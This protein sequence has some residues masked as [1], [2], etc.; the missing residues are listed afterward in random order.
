MN[1]AL[2][3]ETRQVPL[4]VM[5]GFQTPIQQPIQLQQQPIQPQQ[6]PI[7]PIQPQYYQTQPVQS[8]IVESRNLYDLSQ[9]MY[10]K[11]EICFRQQDKGNQNFIPSDPAKAF[12]QKSGLQL[13]T[14]LNLWELVDQGRKGY[15]SKNEFIVAVHL[16]AL[17]RKDIPL[18][19]F[20]PD[21]LIQILKK[22][23][24]DQVRSTSQTVQPTTSKPLQ[25][26]P[27]SQTQQ[28]NDSQMID[29]KKKEIDFLNQTIMK[30]QSLQN[31][32]KNEQDEFAAQLTS[33]SG[34]C[35]QKQQQ[36]TALQDCIQ[37]QLQTNQGLLK[38]IFELKQGAGGQEN[39]NQPQ[40]AFQTIHV[41]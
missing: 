37:N 35:A 9:D 13:T 30:L 28:N 38:Q 17:C 40:T 5:D 41:F 34:Q 1:D 6:Q 16:I 4:P 12:F 19:Q 26:I 31:N 18:P 27:S 15:L 8:Q 39:Q 36:M 23:Q 3:N 14:L 7:Q 33:L 2:L 29:D 22:D 10:A 21:S 11:Y 32:L 20:L 24:Q 25:R